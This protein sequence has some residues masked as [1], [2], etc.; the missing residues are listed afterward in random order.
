MSP[1]TFAEEIKSQVKGVNDK[2]VELHSKTMFLCPY[3]SKDAAAE[4][5]PHAAEDAARE[6]AKDVY[7]VDGGVLDNA[8]FDLVIDA[9]ARRRAQTQVYRQL[10]YIEPD[11]GQALYSTIKTGGQSKRGSGSRIWWQ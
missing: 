7:F 6:A 8:P 5:D 9:I 1:G 2:D 4:L 11:P 10:I 3:G